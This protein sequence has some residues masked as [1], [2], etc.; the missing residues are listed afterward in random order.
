MSIWVSLAWLAGCGVGYVIGHNH[1][2]RAYQAADKIS[3]GVRGQ[4]RKVR[5]N[6]RFVGEGWESTS[7]ATVTTVDGEFEVIVRQSAQPRIVSGDA[8]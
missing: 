1:G 5:D 6:L 2:W 8:A 4:M 7:K 3:Q